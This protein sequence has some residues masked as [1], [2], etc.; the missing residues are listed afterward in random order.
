MKNSTPNSWMNKTVAS[1]ILYGIQGFN[2]LNSFSQETLKNGGSNTPI[3]PGKDGVSE[4]TVFVIG[5][6]LVGSGDIVGE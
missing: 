1:N 2:V 4:A 3:V 5:M 6:S